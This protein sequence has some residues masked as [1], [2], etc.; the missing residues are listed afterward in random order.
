MMS[1]QTSHDSISHSHTHLSQDDY[2][3]HSPRETLTNTVPRNQKKSVTFDMTKNTYHE[4]ILP[5]PQ[6]LGK[7]PQ[8]PSQ[9]YTQPT[10]HN[11]TTS[12]QA[13]PTNT[14]TYGDFPSTPKP[15][16]TF[17]ILSANIN[18][19]ATKNITQEVHQIAFQADAL[20]TDYLALIETNLNWS[21]A[22]IRAQAQ[23]II[24]KYWTQSL[25]TFSSHPTS[26]SKIYL[27][28]GTLSI[29]GNAWS[30]GAH[31][32][33]D[34]SGMGRWT[35]NTITGRNNRKITFITA[36]RVPKT[37]IR[38]AGSSTSFFHQWHH[39]RREGHKSPDPRENLLSDI[40]KHICSISDASTAV[41]A[42]ID[43]NENYT[44][45]QSSLAKWAQAHHLV[46]LH[47]HLH[48]LST[49]IPTY[50][51]G[52]Y[53]IDYIF[54]THAILPYIVQGGILPYHL[55]KNTDHRSLYIDIELQ[56]SS[57]TKNTELPRIT[58]EQYRVTNTITSKSRPDGKTTKE[59]S[60]EHYL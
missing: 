21:N 47:M 24:R 16:H 50:I 28:G 18:G 51:R 44:S 39:L 5:K 52:Q 29:L 60:G 49:D 33:S 41:I 56:R 4:A 59:N 53:R 19:I 37:T 54:G 10:L 42:M 46:D 1:S 23:S 22:T 43:A 32:V 15:S 14:D 27:P 3:H 2:H 13:P 38:Q 40:S 12:I 17:R 34:S 58:V 7:S 57:H 36:Y 6:S 20:H 55:L 48:D 31:R 35:S 8:R 45:P 26:T 25:I 30:G 9:S 11:I